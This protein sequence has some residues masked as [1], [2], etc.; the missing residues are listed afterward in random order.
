[1]DFPEEDE[2]FLAEGQVPER[3]AELEERFAALQRDTRQG[4]LLRDGI[5]VALVGPP[6]VG[7]SSLLNR[8]AGQER[9]IVTEIPGTTRDLI[10]ADL[11]LDGM[12]VQVVDT[13]GLRESRDPV[14]REG[15]RRAR[16]QASRAD[17]V[18]VLEDDRQ[19]ER[20]D[21][22]TE[23]LAAGIEPARLLRVRN[24]ADLSGAVPGHAGLLDQIDAV[25]VSALTGAGLDA[26]VDAIKRKVNF[27]GEG[28][29]F[30]ARRRHIDALEEAGAALGRA[31]ELLATRAPPELVAEELRTVH[32]A[33]GR[34]VGAVSADD[35]LGEIF[36][37]FCIGT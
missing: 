17:L 19:P 12:P 8:L 34:I 14:E 13:A 36:S 21:A 25:R 37:S 24:K 11:T 7:K 16:E 5:A 23:L 33:L 4:V 32:A 30:T 15:V 31:G 26:L 9:A 29:A 28:A 3:L 6:N 27:A 10:R 1:M 22:V 18:L 20:G 2:D 35:L